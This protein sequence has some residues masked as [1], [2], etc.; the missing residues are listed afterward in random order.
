MHYLSIIFGLLIVST[1]AFGA[2]KIVC[3]QDGRPYDGT[4]KKV[5]VELNDQGTYDVYLEIKWAG[6]LGEGEERHVLAKNIS[7]VQIVKDRL[8]AAGHKSSSEEGEP[9]NSGFSFNRVNEEQV[10][11]SSGKVTESEYIK[12]EVFSPLIKEIEDLSGAE[13]GRIEFQFDIQDRFSKG[14]FAN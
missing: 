11:F 7:K 4:Y 12:I 3:E 1:S 6:F 13:N 14:C 9:T 8:I 2:E 5:S 10:D